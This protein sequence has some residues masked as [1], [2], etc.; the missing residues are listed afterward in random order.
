MNKG[1]GRSLSEAILFGFFGQKWG[2]L[3]GSLSKGTSHPRTKPGGELPVRE[4]RF[5]QLSLP[6]PL[7]S[8]CTYL[9]V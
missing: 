3:Q 9:C 4:L 1:L 5:K 8:R 2:E 7:P 6:L